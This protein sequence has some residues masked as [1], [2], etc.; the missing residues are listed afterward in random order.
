MNW[1]QR[2]KTLSQTLLFVGCLSTTLI[3]GVVAGGFVARSVFDEVWHGDQRAMAHYHTVL[4]EIAAH[5]NFL[6]QANRLAR[7]M[8]EVH[9]LSDMPKRLIE[10]LGAMPAARVTTLKDFPGSPPLTVFKSKMA[11]AAKPQAVLRLSRQARQLAVATRVMLLDAATRVS[12]TRGELTYYISAG[13]DLAVMRPA[14]P[15]LAES[16]RYEM[17]SHF[18]TAMLK[19]FRH[20]VLDASR[21]THGPLWLLPYR[22]PLSGEKTLTVFSPVQDPSGELLGFIAKDFAWGSLL[23]K[24]GTPR[25]AGG[26]SFLTDDDGYAFGENDALVRRLCQTG[27]EACMGRGTRLHVLLRDGT[28]LIEQSTPSSGWRVVYSM[29]LAQIF[30]AHQA[31]IVTAIAIFLLSAGV[32]GASGIL[33]QRRYVA[34]AERQARAL[35]ESEAFRRTI[36]ELAPIGLVIIQPD[37]CLVLLRNECSR[38]M[39]AEDVPTGEADAPGLTVRDIVQAH[40]ESSGRHAEFEAAE[41]AAGLRRCFALDFAIVQYQGC[42]VLLCA[43]V[44]VTQRRRME[45]TLATAKREAEAANRAKSAFLATV[46][47]EIRTPLYGTLAALELMSVQRLHDE[48]RTLL[49]MM[50]GSARNLLQLINDLLDF[51]KLEADQLALNM[52]PFNLRDELEQVVRGFAAHAEERGLKLRCFIDPRFERDIVGDPLRISQIVTNLVSN[53]LKFTPRG[54]IDLYVDDDDFAST[55]TRGS[56]VPG[57]PSLR[58]RVAD[59]GVGM[60]RERLSN[61]FQPFYQA[62]APED[63]MS[64]GT[65]LGLSIVRSLATLMHGEVDVMSVYGEGSVFSVTLPLEWAELALPIHQEQAL[66]G[67]RIDVY[68]GDEEEARFLAALLR[69]Y[70]AQPLCLT[71]RRPDG[72]HFEPADLVL[73]VRNAR[74]PAHCRALPCVVLDPLGGVWPARRG[75]IIRVSAYSQRGMLLALCE[76][77]GRKL[78]GHEQIETVA[79]ANYGMRVVVVEDHPVNRSLLARQ[80][81][82]FGCET[83]LAADGPAALHLILAGPAVD[84]VLTDINMPGMDGYQLAHALREAGL[85]MPIYGVTA[86]VI[87]RGKRAGDTV[88]QGCLPKPL[89]LAMLAPVLRAVAATLAD[90]DTTVIPSVPARARARTGMQGDD[91]DPASFPKDIRAMMVDTMDADMA[92]LEAARHADDD[93]ALAE[94]RQTLHRIQG[95]T[96]AVGWSSMTKLVQQAR[97]ALANDEHALDSIEDVLGHWKKSRAEWSVT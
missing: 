88:I 60:R 35:A 81:K 47:H 48:Q 97:D 45:E 74:S 83:L 52:R 69:M 57:S 84:L 51:T 16:A 33:I 85:S 7:E 26:F 14:L 79:R 44:D 15:A 54:N 18:V 93:A 32:V 24:V 91:T 31:T 38:S 61:L 63:A 86:D 67:L 76:A 20:S 19:R 17:M 4:T 40:R 96:L 70:G 6:Q 5:E 92:R 87:E 46:S 1:R 21:A 37:D 12:P 94:M 73:C 13:G 80:L 23:T 39:I 30:A 43:I 34:P 9:V 65:G 78:P 66:Q 95:A 25:F 10:R 68:G 28:I 64:S 50:D 36:F 90:S 62:A 58:I 41:D 89:S 2:D 59:S 53:A 75:A 11:P 71:S 27:H 55:S 8:F 22:H 42:P 56:G 77:V 3:V 72:E 49:G 29:P 82:H